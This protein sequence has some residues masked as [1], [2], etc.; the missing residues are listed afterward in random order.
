MK[1]IATSLFCFLTILMFVSV[2]SAQDKGT[3]TVAVYGGA[4][5][6]IIA[7][8]MFKPFE[9]KFGVKVIP[10][11]GA[12]R[13]TL[14]KLMQQKGDPLID[15]ACMDS[16]ISELAL[17]E[18]VLEFMDPNKIP[19]LQNVLVE[20]L[21][22]NKSGQIYSMG[23]GFN[24]FGITYNKEKVK[25]KPTSWFDLWNKDYAGKVTAPSPAN[26][27]GIPFLVFISQLKGGG[28]NNIEPGIEALKKL[29]VA[30]YFDATGATINM[31]NSGEVIVAAMGCSDGWY[32]ADQNS[33]Y[34][35]AI[36]KEGLITTDPRV[37]LVKNAKNKELAEKFI[38]FVATTEVSK[39]MAEGLYCGP[40][41]TKGVTL[42]EK[43]KERLPYGP[44][45]SV[46]DLRFMDWQEINA[47]RAEMTDRWNKE[48]TRK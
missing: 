4:W 1:R 41:I 43:V 37:H 13:V 29:D 36:P 21:Y 32:L 22:K 2:S 26:G 34:S 15:V 3:L 31:F 23:I 7:K 19:N 24:G 28:I 42:S 39:G 44:T 38:N 45:G 27:W 9:Q 8:T 48:I 30:A 10:E 40:P 17:N 46:K 18:G 25:N 16:G 47:K 35:V 11:P 33:K 20:A 14:T 5:G 6:D 12:S